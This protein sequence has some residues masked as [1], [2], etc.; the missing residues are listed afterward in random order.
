MDIKTKLRAIDA[1][2]NA[3]QV[4]GQSVMHLAAAR[5]MINELYQALPD[6]APEASPTPEEGSN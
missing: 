1:Q 2:L 3:V 5:Q 4:S 6:P